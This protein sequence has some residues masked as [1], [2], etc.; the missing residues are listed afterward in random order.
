MGEQASPLLSAP[1][2]ILSNAGFE[3]AGTLGTVPTSW[4]HDGE[5]E[6]TRGGAHTGVQ[7][8]L[9]GDLIST[10]GPAWHSIDQVMTV[11]ANTRYRVG[12]WV[13]TSPDLTAG[14]IDIRAGS[15]GVVLSHLQFGPAASGYR[16][17]ALEFES[18]SETSATLLIGFVS[19]SPKSWM[20]VDDVSVIPNRISDGGFEMT[21][22]PGLANSWLGDGMSTVGQSSARS[23]SRGVRV[24][25]TDAGWH[26][27]NQFATVRPNTAYVVQGW[28]RSSAGLANIHL[29]IRGSNNAFI[30]GVSPAGGPSWQ[31]VSFTFNSGANTSVLFY[32]G[33]MGAGAGTFL[34][35][36]DLSIFE[37]DPPAVPAGAFTKSISSSGGLNCASLCANG[38]TGPIGVC[39]DGYSD[40]GM[41]APSIGCTTAPANQAQTALTCYCQPKPFRETG[42]AS[43]LT[44]AYTQHLGRLTN[45]QTMKNVGLQGTDNAPSV[46]TSHGR[47]FEVWS[48]VVDQKS[49]QA[50]TFV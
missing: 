28:L 44:K 48:R 19:S 11:Q 46:Q 5:L 7:N 41:G 24:A 39:V 4:A 25:N 32:A 12:V 6:S 43:F 36:D 33:Y 22:G 2:N 20:R 34:D 40:T 3:S 16:Y 27:V 10:P 18:G 17:Q 47:V 23:G 15:N 50:A 13:R 30:A 1:G 8:V 45:A 37:A 35:A 38:N 49:D 14:T 21:P 42:Q 31:R 9:I 26:A 29:D